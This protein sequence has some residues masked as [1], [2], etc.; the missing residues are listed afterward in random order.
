[1][2]TDEMAQAGMSGNDYRFYYF[3]ELFERRVETSGG[4]EDW[5]G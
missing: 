5:A 4:I 1:M 2:A 3:S